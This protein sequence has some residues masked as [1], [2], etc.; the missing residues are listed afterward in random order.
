MRVVSIFG[1]RPEAVKMAP[2]VRALRAQTEIDSRVIVTAQHREMLDQVLGLFEIIPDVD[3]N[4]MRP[5][6]SLA[7]LT[8][9]IFTHL[10][11]VLRDLAPDWMLVQG[12]TTTVMAAAMLGYYRR[13]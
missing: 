6:Q 8:A 11:P 2:V 3:L 7:D 12:D 13:I 1:T 4:L 9:A 5:D 10:D